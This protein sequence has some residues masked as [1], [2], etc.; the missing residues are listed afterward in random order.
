M[1]DPNPAAP[2]LDTLQHIDLLSERIHKLKRAQASAEE[3]IIHRIACDYRTG[4]VGIETVYALYQKLKA[5]AVSG[6][7]FRW[8]LGMPDE[9]HATRIRHTVYRKVRHQP[10]ADGNWRGIYPLEPAERFPRTGTSVVYVLFDD[11]NV[12]CYV[13]STSDFRGR[14]K[15][16]RK[17]G[18]AFVC[19]LA[20]PCADREAA[21]ALEDRLLREHKP[22]LNRKASR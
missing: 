13:G 10:D 9:A 8:S 19:W 11:A 6:F 18:K 4:N 2:Y 20:Y 5:T 12:P 14:S 15:A 1:T 22:Y 16:H 7:P 3:Q 21:Y 17:E